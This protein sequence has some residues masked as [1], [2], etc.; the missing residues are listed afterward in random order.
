MRDSTK[1]EWYNLSFPDP[2]LSTARRVRVSCFQALL[3]LLVSIYVFYPI[4]LDDARRYST[5]K[6]LLANP[7]T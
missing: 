1:P 5:L 7:R 3:A 4:M 6:K 2:L